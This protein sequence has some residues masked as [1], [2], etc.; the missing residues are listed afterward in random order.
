[1]KVKRFAAVLVL[2][3]ALSIR[4]CLPAFAAEEEAVSAARNGVIRVLAINSAEGV[5]SFGTAFAVGEE[6]EPSSVFMTNYHVVQGADVVY[7]LLDNEWDG[8]E[9]NLLNEEHAVKC[10]VVYQPYPEIYPDYAVLRAERVVS[11]RTALPLM[12]ASMASPGETI[13]AIGFPAA[14]DQVTGHYDAEIDDE[15]MTAG[16]LSRL[17]RIDEISTDVVQTDAIINKGNSGGPLITEEGYVIGINTYRTESDIYLAV[18]SEYAIDR[19]SNLVENGT[20]N[21]FS[22][23]VI[24]ERAEGGFS[25][26]AV[27]GIGAAILIAG[28]AVAALSRRKAAAGPAAGGGKTDASSGK[29]DGGGTGNPAGCENNREKTA[30]SAERQKGNR[31]SFGGPGLQKGEPFPKTVFEGGIGKTVPADMVHFLRLVGKEGYFAG[32]RFALDGRIRMG[33]L[34]DK[35]ELVFPADTSGVSGAHCMITPSGKGAVLV[36]LGSSFGTFLEDGTR[37]SPNQ[38]VEIQAGDSFFLGSRKQGFVLESR[39]MS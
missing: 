39:D 26:A 6:G 20:L 15:T 27:V 25:T 33:R 37:L 5:M 3:A 31:E 19:L 35:N 1:M 21:G 18:Q 7:L 8:E 34:P 14:G 38:P 16:T 23:T 13:Y 11:E 28:A 32:R 2:L 4:M 9:G 17:T 36:D 30:S 24:E 12:P 29:T 10:E 22:F